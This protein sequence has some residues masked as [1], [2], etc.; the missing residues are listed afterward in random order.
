M[1]PESAPLIQLDSST[2]SRCCRTNRPFCPRLDQDTASTAIEASLASV[3]E[4]GAATVPEVAAA[5]LTGDLL[6]ANEIG[7]WATLGVMDGSPKIREDGGH[8]A[9]NQT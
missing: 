3:F 2:T 8:D 7:R 6:I 9:H 4:A 1:T 5:R